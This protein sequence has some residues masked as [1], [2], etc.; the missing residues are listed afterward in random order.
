MLYYCRVLAFDIECEKSPL[1]FPNAERDRIFMI[2]YMIST[3]DIPQGY[4]IISREIVSEDIQDFEYTPLPKFPGPFK[5][6]NE[7]NEED[8]LKRFITHVKVN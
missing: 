8:L 2:S 3:N 1:K 5:I 7:A 4:L 6:F